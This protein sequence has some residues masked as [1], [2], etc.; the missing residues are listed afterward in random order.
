LEILRE[1]TI[2]LPKHDYVVDGTKILAYRKNCTGEWLVFKKPMN[3]DKRGRTFD[4][5][6]EKGPAVLDDKSVITVQGSGGKTYTIR[7][8]QCSCPGFGFRGHCKHVEKNT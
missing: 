2:D 8:G 7:N 6:N 4:K 3:F 5:L 1:T